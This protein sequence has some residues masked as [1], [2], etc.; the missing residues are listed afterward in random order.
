MTRTELLKQRADHLLEAGSSQ[1][2][3][4]GLA[5]TNALEQL[6]KSDTSLDLRRLA[7]KRYLELTEP[8]GKSA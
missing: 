1:F 6:L 7:V 5:A 4:R 2:R 3:K 8:E